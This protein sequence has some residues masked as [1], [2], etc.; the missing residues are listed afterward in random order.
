MRR[1]SRV[2]ARAAEEMIERSRAVSESDAVFDLD[3]GHSAERP[4]LTRIKQPHLNVPASTRCCTRR[5]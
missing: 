4:K 1:C 5:G 3:E 2:C